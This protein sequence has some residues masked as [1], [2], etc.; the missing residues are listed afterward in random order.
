MITDPASSIEK[1]LIAA[2]GKREAAAISDGVSIPIATLAELVFGL[3]NAL[4]L[5]GIRKG[6]RILVHMRNSAEYVIAGLAIMLAGGVLVPANVRFTQRELGELMARANA[7]GY[8]ADTDL[9]SVI[10]E[11]LSTDSRNLRF[12]VTPTTV[13]AL[14]EFRRVG[15]WSL[16]QASAPLPDA[17]D[18]AALFFTTGT[19]GRPK[20]VLTSHR[21]LGAYIDIVQ[22]SFG[23]GSGDRLVMP[24]PMYYTGGFKA[25]MAAV[26]LGLDL[27]TER[28][29]SASDLPNL[30]REHRATLVWAV[31]TLWALMLRSASFKPDLMRTVRL[32]WL[33]GSNVPRSLRNELISAFPD[34]PHYHNY[35]LTECNFATVE[36]RGCEYPNSAGLPTVG[37][38]ISIDGLSEPDKVG[39]IWV[40]GRQ[41]FSGYADS[42][43]ISARQRNGWIRTGDQGYL[44]PDGRLTVIGRLA[45]M[46]RRGGENIAL[47]EVERVIVGLASVSEAVVLAVPNEVFGHELKA[48]VVPTPGRHFD[49]DLVRKECMG[50]LAE[51]KVPK[52]WDV[53]HTPLP[54]NE[55][56]KVDRK[57]LESGP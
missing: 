20:G 5:R 36:P 6:D 57:L 44:Q 51:F 45:D 49:L 40:S 3:R 16:P 29:W 54:R 2:A 34:K 19:T 24:M 31:P 10:D 47:A 42:E 26:L 15:D 43:F 53:R 56:G 28:I 11:L 27:I 7:V 4:I 14:E 30:V 13:G 8:F 52:Y 21:A 55:S 48:I 35:G 37:T 38:R 23:F 25:S 41:E 18:I 1:R 39:E 17:E 9:A 12:P 22:S 46:A 33:G 32:L 50:L